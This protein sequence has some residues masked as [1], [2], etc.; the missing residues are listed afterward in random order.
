[1][2]FSFIYSN[3][4]MKQECIRPPLYISKVM[5][6]KR[7]TT[8]MDVNKWLTDGILLLYYIHLELYSTSINLEISVWQNVKL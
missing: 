7:I 1:M 5:D 2:N 8:I 3:S 4:I 6:V